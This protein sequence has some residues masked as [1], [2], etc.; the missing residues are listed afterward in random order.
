MLDWLD[1]SSIPMGF[2]MIQP[3]RCEQITLHSTK[4]ESLSGFPMSCNA[5]IIIA[6]DP[7]YDKF[8]SLSGFPMSCN[9]VSDNQGEVYK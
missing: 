9:F 2:P 3:P 1:A 7:T 4:F 5:G 6:G 8:Q